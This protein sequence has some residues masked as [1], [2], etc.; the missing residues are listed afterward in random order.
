MKR[1]ENQLIEAH[2]L[3]QNK[4]RELE[5]L[6][7]QMK[8]LKS[9]TSLQNADEPASHGHDDKK[10]E[11]LEPSRN[12][13][14]HANEHLL[15]AVANNISIPLLPRKG[16]DDPATLSDAD[17]EIVKLARVFHLFLPLPRN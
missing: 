5:R 17:K 4:D 13:T 14:S 16:S 15:A 10:D 11:Q 2:Q 7:R 6:N 12:H 8:Y 1:F 3:S 9:R